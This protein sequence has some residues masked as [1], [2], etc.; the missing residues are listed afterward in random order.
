MWLSTS[1]LALSVPGGS[2]VHRSLLE[3]VLFSSSLLGATV[4]LSSGY[5][6]ESN[7]QTERL[8]QELETCLK[9]LVAQN[10]TTWSQHLTWVEYAQQLPAH[11]GHR[12]LSVP[13]GFWVPA[14]S[15]PHQRDRGNSTFGSRHGEEVSEDLGRRTADAPEEPVQD[16]G[17][18]RPSPQT[19]TSLPSRPESL[20]IHK[21]PA[22]S[23]PQ[24]QTRS[25]SRLSS[26]V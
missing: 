6:P 24:P 9:C 14:S 12:V 10:Q 18:R 8:N 26:L 20:A 19:S 21:R 7:G 22:S 5:H 13:S 16:E 17:C 1:K 4:S 23:C 11:C 25:Q 3:G 2:T 15:L